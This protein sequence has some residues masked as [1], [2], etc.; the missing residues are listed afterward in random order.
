MYITTL[1]ILFEDNEKDEL[2]I[3]KAEESLGMI[4]NTGRKNE[5]TKV[6]FQNLIQLVW[7][8]D[9]DIFKEACDYFWHLLIVLTEEEKTENNHFDIEQSEKP[10]SEEKPDTSPNRL[11]EYQNN[12]AIK[13]S[14]TTKRHKYLS[15]FI[16]EFAYL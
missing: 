15:K 12:A 7:E 11:R 2:R 6:P 3:Q 10:K 8:K 4:R 5:S 9:E 14:F 1:K 16:F 13:K